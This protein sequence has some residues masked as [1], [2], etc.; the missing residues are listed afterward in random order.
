MLAVLF[1]KQNR[2]LFPQ[3][4]LWPRLR[5]GVMLLEVPG[6]QTRALHVQTAHSMLDA[7]LAVE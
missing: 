7:G 2:G 4:Q 5:Q 3:V 1:A 6:N